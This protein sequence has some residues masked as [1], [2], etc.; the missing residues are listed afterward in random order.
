MVEKKINLENALNNNLDTE[1]LSERINLGRSLGIVYAEKFNSFLENNPNPTKD[2]LLL[3]I[4]YSHLSNLKLSDLR[5]D[6]DGLYH[7]AIK[8]ISEMN[9]DDNNSNNN[10][11]NYHI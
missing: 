7:R 6:N 2:K 5:D 10:N 4:G 11:S 9:F 1:S 8:S 3:M